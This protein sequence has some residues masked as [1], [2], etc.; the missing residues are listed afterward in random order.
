M[1]HTK[2][3][4]EIEAYRSDL[5][6]RMRVLK[7]G[8]VFKVWQD[9]FDEV[10]LESRKLLEIKL[11]YIHNNPLQDRWALVQNPED[12]KYSSAGLYERGQHST[13]DVKHYMDFI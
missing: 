10:Y 1:W 9:R 11:D 5:L 8:Q 3:R 7:K 2:I 4:K 12:Y 13:I 6:D